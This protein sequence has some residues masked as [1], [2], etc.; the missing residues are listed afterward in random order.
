MGWHLGID[1]IES[2]FGGACCHCPPV[3]NYY[4]R[5]IMSVLFC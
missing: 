1:D 4:T 3:S 5:V 2:K